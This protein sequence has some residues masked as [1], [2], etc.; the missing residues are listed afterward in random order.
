MSLITED[1]SLLLWAVILLTVT[2]AIYLEQRFK[3]AASIGAIVI[4]ILAG[5]ALANIHLIPY[6]S[7]T[8]SAIGSV[9]LPCAIP[10]FLFKANIKQILKESGRMFVIFHIAAV[11]TIIGVMVA[12]LVF[13]SFEA[14]KYLCTI[15]TAAA[16]GGTVNCVAI[17]NIFALPD[18][19]LSSYL[20]TGNL[21]CGLMIILFR[22][23]HN[24]KFIRTFLPH[25]YTDKVET[26]EDESSLAKS[27][28]TH[29][30]SFWGSKEIGLKDIATALT[31]TFCIVAVSS[32]IANAVLSL[33]PP[34]II[35]QSFGSVYL[36]MTLLTT[37]CAT[38]LPKFFGNIKGAMEL[39]NIGLLVWF[40][41]IGCSGNLI[42]IIKGS[43]LSLGILFF[44]I[45]INMA[46]SIIG[47]KLLKGTWEDAVCATTATVGG[48]PTAAAVTI[49]FGWSE[50]VVPGI[51][52]GLWGYIIGTYGGII[53]G[54]LI[55][56]PSLL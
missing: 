10:L 29:A 19:M 40:F 42:E 36:I 38:L 1:Q 45:T 20:V 26:V 35:A 52:V 32:L 30:A 25:P 4:V 15:I 8:Y 54:N 14:T 31:A 12:Y 50:L 51:L 44:T 18:G 53:V 9:L 49:S 21:V 7:P 28:A 11:G 13:H 5:L 2:I 56:V 3:W 43:A 16:I 23:L 17:G 22:V 47:A 39:G 6:A 55:G 33:N 27:G 24:T 34:T 37:A 46:L 41:T 48:P